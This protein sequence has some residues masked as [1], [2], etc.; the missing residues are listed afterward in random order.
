M[1]RSSITA[2]MLAGSLWILLSVGLLLVVVAAHGSATHG[3]LERDPARVDAKPL[4]DGVS[5]VS[6]V[7]NLRRT[8]TNPQYSIHRV[9]YESPP[10]DG[11]GRFIEFDLQK[12]V[13]LQPGWR[14]VLPNPVPSEVRQL[15]FEALSEADA[16][17]NDGSTASFNI[18]FSVRGEPAVG[19]AFE[20]SVEGFELQPGVDSSQRAF[21]SAQGATQAPRAH[22]ISI[23]SDGPP[24]VESAV[25]RDVDGDG[26]VDAY[27]IEFSEPVREESIFAYEFIVGGRQGSAHLPWNVATNSAA[28][29]SPGGPVEAIL[30]SFP[31]AAAIDTGARPQLHYEADFP[32]NPGIEDFDQKVLFDFGDDGVEEQ[33]G[34]APKLREATTR[35][36]VDGKVDGVVLTFTEAVDTSSLQT[37]HLTVQPAVTGASIVDPN[38][39]DATVLL[40]FVGAG[41]TAHRP[42]IRYVGGG[43]VADASG[44]AMLPMAAA[45]LS[46]DR[47]EPTILSATT[48]DLSPSDIPDGRI[49]AYRIVF[50][51]GINDGSVV[52]GQWEVGGGTYTITSVDTGNDIGSGPD[53]ATILLR[54]QEGSP[55][56]G[57]VPSL[58]YGAFGGV[59]VN[60]TA[61]NDLADVSVIQERR[62]D[63]ARPAFVLLPTEVGGQHLDMVFSEPVSGVA[64]ESF[65]YHDA[66]GIGGTTI[67]QAVYYESNRTA[68]LTLDAPL[69]EDD[70]G[71][72]E[73]SITTGAITDAAG[74]TVD[75]AVR[76]LV[77]SDRPFL[78]SVTGNVGSTAL[79]IR[80]TEAVESATGLALDFDDLEISNGA[81]S[82]LQFLSLD[83]TNRPDVFSAVLSSPLE[84]AHINQN[85]APATVSV[86]QDSVRRVGAPG[87]FV[88]VIAKNVRDIEAPTLQAATTV[89]QNGNGFIDAVRL[90]FSEKLSFVNQQTHLDTAHWLIKTERREDGS[91][92]AQVLVD[93]DSGRQ[94]LLVLG[95]D[96]SPGDERPTISY[97][98]EALTDLALPAN[99]MRTFQDVAARDGVIPLVSVSVAPAAPN[100]NGWYNT[101]PQIQLTAT[102]STASITYGEAN[103]V[104]DLGS[105][106]YTGPFTPLLQG[107]VLITYAATDRAGNEGTAASFTVKIDTNRPGQLVRP[108]N[109]RTDSQGIIHLAWEPVQDLVP[110]SGIAHYVVKVGDA[111]LGTTQGADDRAFQHKPQVN[112]TYSYTV[113]AMDVAGN[114][115]PDSP[116]SNPVRY[117]VLGGSTGG[118]TTGGGGDSGGGANPGLVLTEA[119]IKDGNVKLTKSLSI[120][121]QGATNILEWASPADLGL[122]ADPLGIQIWRSDGGVFLCVATLSKGTDAYNNLEYKDDS[123]TNSAES[124]YVLTVFYGLS[125]ALG[126]SVDGS[127]STSDCSGS[128]AHQPSNVP[129]F[130][131]LVQE[132]DGGVPVGEGRETET[133]YPWWIWPLLILFILS[134]IAVAAW[135]ALRWYRYGRAESLEME[136]D[137]EFSGYTWD[138]G[139]VDDDALDDG[140]VATSTTTETT[141]TTEHG[142]PEA[143]EDGNNA[144]CPACESR[145]FIEGER[146]VKATCP[147]CGRAGILH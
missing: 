2:R 128:A 56:S 53:D 57:T 45:L 65:V 114:R 32:T 39:S 38:P 15:V 104:T 50:S 52:V 63:G 49:D 66:N 82:V 8:V 137:E 127:T 98:G 122:P 143:D 4:D 23:V 3:P 85:G 59:A 55:D 125:T 48:L 33:D 22:T 25:T 107:E 116:A 30:L 115:A 96:V 54:L 111:V 60:D 146:P 13:A 95:D 142:G 110:G 73:V 87:V 5:F 68:V 76:A 144:Q 79:T 90:V 117:V 138:E 80:F 16:I 46:L 72:E 147:S 78:A 28:Q 136:E 71:T 141:T 58:D 92:P 44:N 24:T 139:D 89:D 101:R 112:G 131:A 75:P 106:S 27:L 12:S 11:T 88:P 81:G 132:T 40:Q 19:T 113:A 126:F 47:A 86:V 51:E 123:P 20:V 91:A 97:V 18:T 43:S 135:M 84:V 108:P 21:R 17:P 133:R 64:P 145:F 7:E 69:N 103:G 109:V 120:A 140:L 29:V 35:G 26:R 134:I 118:G 67:Q 70:I 14:L 41:D 36:S 102:E 99:Q 1:F 130:T 9:V 100:Q 6:E 124:R 42:Q 105:D 62:H 34:V 61:R 31:P 129:G 119:Q 121:R 37:Q 74:N 77:K 83:A 94:L 10:D 93:G